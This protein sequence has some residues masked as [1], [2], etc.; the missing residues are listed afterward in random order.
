[1]YLDKIGNIMT[2]AGQHCVHSW[3]KSKGVK[4]SCRLSFYFY[5]TEEEAEIFIEV[6]KQILKLI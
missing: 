1:M 5:N 6:F 4:N 3:F 2:R